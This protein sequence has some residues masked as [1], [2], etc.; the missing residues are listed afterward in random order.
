MKVLVLG[1]NGMLGHMV[2]K[3]LSEY[4]D[5][6]GTVRAVTP[7][8]CEGTDKILTGIN[9][10]NV[11]PIIELINPDVIV[12]CI[13]IIKQRPSA[14]MMRVNAE[15]P[16]EL[17]ELSAKKQIRLIHISTDC[18]FRGHLGG[19]TEDNDVPLPTDLYG[20]SKRLGEL[21]SGALTLRTS[22]I[23]PELDSKYGLLEWFLSQE[24]CNGYTNAV[25]SGLTT[26]ELAKVINLMVD[27]DLE[28]LYHVAG[29]PVNK[30]DLLN[31]IK[32]VYGLTTEITPDE[33]VRIDRSLNADRFRV[34]T[35]YVSPSWTEMVKEMYERLNTRTA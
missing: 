2:F 30:F 31:I 18:V 8:M 22:I 9:I 5:T 33:S 28:G 34:A 3:Y 14:G 7:G 6:Y 16:H 25:F 35:G 12:N 20:K 27:S 24:R 15:F 4:H 32:D 19:Y 13:G 29:P 11:A 10:E 17:L 1:A 23:G 21:K 26:L